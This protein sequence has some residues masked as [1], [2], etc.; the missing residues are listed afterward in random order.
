MDDVTYLHGFVDGGGLAYVDCVGT[1]SNGTNLPPTADGAN[2]PPRE[3]QAFGGPWD[4]PHYSWALKS[5]VETYAAILNG[6]KQ[7]CVTEF[8]YASPIEG[9][10]PGNFA[11][12][13]DVS[14][15][16]QAD[17]VVEAFNWMRASGQ[18]KMAF[19]F[20]LD[21]APKGGDPGEDDNVIFSIL[22]RNGVP[23]PAFDALSVMPKP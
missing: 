22:D 7:Q 6:Q 18:V 14:E 17:Y 16:Q 13:A 1:H 8:G 2:P 11:F 15:Q 3:G 5:Q 4:N 12:A 9:R 20:N 19:L 21:Y 23:R 10:Y